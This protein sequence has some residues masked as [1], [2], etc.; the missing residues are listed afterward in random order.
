MSDP[1]LAIQQAYV[2]RL[3]AEV[4][5]VAGRVHDRAPPN[6]QF[7]F[8]QIGDIEVVED[9]AECIDA[10]ECTITLHIW[11]RG[12]GRV[13]SRELA[14]AVRAALHEWIPN[15]TPEG[16]RCVEHMHRD[17]RQMADPDGETAHGILTF[18]ILVDLT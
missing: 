15:L 17:T 8:L 9:G 12:I 10:T 5:G 7:P 14:G 4:T 16:F 13:Q 2:A 3:V 1:S 6:V 11:S 18:R